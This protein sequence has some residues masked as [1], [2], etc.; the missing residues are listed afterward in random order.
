MSKPIVSLTEYKSSPFSLEKALRE[1]NAFE[2]LE[3][4]HRV[5]IK[6]NV[7][8][9]DPDYPLAPYGVYTTSRLVEDMVILLKEHG[10][11]DITI[12]E[13]S[14]RRVGLKKRDAPQGTHL[15]FSALGYHY[16]QE[17]YGVRLLDFFD[18]PFEEVELDDF[19]INI[20]KAALETDFF[21]NMPVLKTHNQTKLSLGL[22]N[23]K[24]C[25]DI[26]SRRFCH[27]EDI[28]LDLFCSLYVEAIKPSLTVL[29]GIYGLEKG[30]YYLGTAHRM[31]VI[32][33]SQDPLAVDTMGALVAGFDPMSVDS[34]ALY[35]KRHGRSTDP[36]SFVVT[37][38]QPEDFQR[39]LKWDFSWR[40]DNTGPKNW[41]KIGI[42]GI[43]IPKYDQSICT[44][45][46]TMFNPLIMFFTAAYKGKPFDGIEVLSGKKMTP[47][48][49]FNR[50]ILFGNC[51][52]KKNRN[53][54]NIKEAVYMKGCPVY[55]EEIIGTL[56]TMGIKPD[57]EFYSR[58]RES[59]V[60][61]YEGNPDFDPG[62]YFL[63]GATGHQVRR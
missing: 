59:L 25:I 55:L 22:K 33:A 54:P 43:S 15:I 46:S 18:E 2:K 5:L 31:N 58:F 29:D 8:G 52:I 40:E 23:L 41:D 19:S 4:G 17:R 32:I 28:P 35:A 42:S 16:L 53:D 39:P 44:G 13:G 61:R 24:G 27:N 9:W 36:G 45:C 10:I 30:P 60:H 57:L 38:S 49:G 11:Q 50:T 37:G 51:M 7:V 34:I 6:P 26:K 62:H 47:S 48:P 21:I 12:G 1:S 63:P 14:V 56:E 3:P 20:S